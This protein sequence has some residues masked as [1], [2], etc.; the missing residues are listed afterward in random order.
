L[1]RPGRLLLL[2]LGEQGLDLVALLQGGIGEEL[3]LG[4]PAHLE[5][6]GQ[7]AAQEAAGPAQGLARAVGLGSSPSTV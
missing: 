6:L 2:D 5:H 4:H 1:G 7:V 3:Q